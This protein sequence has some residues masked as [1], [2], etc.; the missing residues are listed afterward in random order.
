MSAAFRPEGGTSC[1]GL[2]RFVRIIRRPSR[3]AKARA[4]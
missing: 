3:K 1:A 4:N 2:S